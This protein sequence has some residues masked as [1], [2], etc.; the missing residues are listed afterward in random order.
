MLSAVFLANPD[1]VILIEKQYREHVDRSRIDTALVS[2]ANHVVPPPPIINNGDST[3]ILYRQDEIWI[4]GVCDGDESLLFAVAVLQDI[5]H[6]LHQIAPRGCDED[7]IKSEFPTIYQMLDYAID[8]GFPFLNEWNTIRTVM[9]RP[10]ND[11][12]RGLKTDLDFEKPWRSVGIER[13]LNSFE[14]GVSE[15]IDLVVSPVGRVE[16]C[17]IRG[18]IGVRCTVSGTP[19]F[20]VVLSPQPRFDDVTFHRCVTTDNIETKTIAFVPPDGFFTLMTYRVTVT[21]TE[22]P[23][24]AVP[25]FAWVRGCMNFEITLKVQ[26]SLQTAVDDLEVQFEV[27]NGVQMPTMSCYFGK[28][29]YD[30]GTRAVSWRIGFYS[31]KDPLVLKGTATT[32]QGFEVGR[33]SPPVAV[34]F[35]LADATVSKLTIED[36]SIVNDEYQWTKSIEYVTRTGS[37]EFRTFTG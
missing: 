7:A 33:R 37:Y 28:T 19:D 34:C 30:I 13:I 36:I 6:L 26:E 24:W 17:H 14:I 35:K 20:R 16:L 23:I 12:S 5:G 1:G 3:V 22:F 4:I 10:P 9:S 2:I 29:S 21:Q 18:E 11:P 31:R 8:W 15:R 25:K 32:E 27:P